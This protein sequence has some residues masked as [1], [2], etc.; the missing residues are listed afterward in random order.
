MTGGGGF[1]GMGDMPEAYDLVVN[2]NHPL[3]QK[4]LS[5]EDDTRGDL[6]A[7]AKDLA[8]LQQGMLTG[9]ALTEFVKRATE[10]L[11]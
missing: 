8:L 1:M 5:S 4:I 10:R 11:S 3:A 9:E 7:H 2:G 6:I